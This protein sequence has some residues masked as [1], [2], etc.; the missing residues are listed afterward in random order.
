MLKAGFEYDDVVL[1]QSLASR[2]GRLFCFWKVREGKARSAYANVS[3]AFPS[4]PVLKLPKD[5]PNSGARSELAYEGVIRV[6]Q[7]LSNANRPSPPPPYDKCPSRFRAIPVV[8]RREVHYYVL[9]FTK[10]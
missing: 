1:L 9:S 10:G 7:R 5:L 8:H 6:T 3:P 2:D 4:N